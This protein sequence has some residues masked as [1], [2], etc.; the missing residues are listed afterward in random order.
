MEQISR[1]FQEGGVWMYPLVAVSVF[2]FA[3]SMERVFYY[4]IH[5]RINAKALLT[6]ITRHVRN[7][8][9]EKARQICARTKSPLS[10]I[11]ESALW[12]YQQQ[13]PDQEIQNAIDEVALREL[14]RIQRRTH[15]LSLF[16]NIATLLG[17]LGTIFGLQDAFGALTAADPSQ[18][19]SV[20]A[21]GIAIAMNTTALGLI[22]AIPC[23]ISFSILGAKANT[24][25]E[26]IDESSV[27]LLNFLFSQRRV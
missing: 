13:E 14:P 6:Q 3:V 16:A 5:C 24:I 27:R 9:V 12:H 22:V 11:L 1:F 17:L 19:A 18:K 20:L 15:Y 4:Y 7:G 25:I 21:K 26:E 2:A 10:V 8:D 23:M